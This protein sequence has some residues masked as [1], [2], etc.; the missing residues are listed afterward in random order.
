MSHFGTILKSLVLS[1]MLIASSSSL[2]QSPSSLPLG[3]QKLIFA[4]QRLLSR[5]V[6]EDRV[7]TPKDNKQDE[8][9]KPENEKTF[10]VKSYWI[11]KS[12]LETFTSEHM[13]PKLQNIFFKRSAN[14]QEFALLLV[15]PESESFYE[16][17][18]ASAERGPKFLATS[19]ASSRTLVMW[20]YE[21]PNL[22]F[23]GKLSLNKEIGGVVRTIP[24]G[25]VARSLGTTEVLFKNQHVLPS[26]FKFL[27]EVM[28]A[29]PKGWPRGGMIIREIPKDLAS[30]R[31]HFIPLFSLYADRGDLPPLLAEM[32]QKSGM[33]PKTF[34]EQRIIAPFVNQWLELVLIHGISMEPHAQNV[35]IGLDQNG[36]PNGKFMHRDFGGFN[37]DL[38]SFRKLN[39]LI[40]SELPHVTSISEDY[41]Q[42]FSV[43]SVNE[44]LET[45]F[46]QGFVYN[47]DKK[48]PDWV[49]KGWISNYKSWSFSRSVFSNILYKNLIEGIE[50]LSAGKVKVNRSKIDANL[51]QIIEDARNNSPFMIGARCETIFQ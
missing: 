10:E 18:T 2:A 47:L 26:S 24:Q 25:E 11:Q 28:S 32:I 40:P 45:F 37:L 6:N 5:D 15:H 49:T 19:T 35:L 36:L 48:M 13:S 4:E 14:G 22:A 39:T 44:S 50:R 51:Y 43:S 17:L 38:K 27:P 41:H 31:D 46:E 7:M 42:K 21:R 23:F 16:Q 1:V 9:F 3:I 8:Q 20:P 12:S 34:V 30:G 29:I 33:D